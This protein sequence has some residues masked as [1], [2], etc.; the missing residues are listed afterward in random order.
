VHEP[1]HVRILV[2]DDHPVVRE[3]LRTIIG[4][5][6]G[7]SIVAEARN[8]TSAITKILS[9]R[10]DVALLDVRMPGMRAAEGVA[11]IRKALPDTKIVLISAF[12]ADE[13]VYSV[14]QAGA[15]GFLVKGCPSGEISLC[16]NAVLAGKTW[17]PPGPAAKFAAHFRT[18]P[19]T[20]HQTQIL[21]LV[22][23]GKS[24]KEVGAALSI[25]EG[26]VKVHLKKIFGKLGVASRVE[27]FRTALQRG[28][29]RL[30]KRF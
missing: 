24:N 11:A 14:F 19:L 22:A 29:I 8:W 28:I 9:H 23:E 25:T 21:Q 1:R 12:D 6:P 17:L 4:K 27:A 5:I 20:D 18:S 7:M 26:T 16:L 15:N 10:P 2:A 13:D 3:G 30:E